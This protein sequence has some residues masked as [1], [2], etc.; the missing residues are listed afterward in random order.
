MEKHSVVLAQLDPA[1]IYGFI[2]SRLS[3]ERAGSL[4][5]DAER[6]AVE[7]LGARGRPLII[8]LLTGQADEPAVQDSC[9]IESWMDP[10]FLRTVVHGAPRADRAVL[11]RRE[12]LP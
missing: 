12:L 11:R 5:D 9:R 2:P 8:E 7:M 3:P 1:A 10:D 6:R 4:L